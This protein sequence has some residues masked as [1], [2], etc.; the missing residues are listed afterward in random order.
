MFIF[1]IGNAVNFSFFQGHI[2]PFRTEA[3]DA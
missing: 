2:K 1:A 3:G